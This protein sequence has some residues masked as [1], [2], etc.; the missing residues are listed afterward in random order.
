MHIPLQST[1]PVGRLPSE[2]RYP[3]WY[4]KTCMVWL[5]E[6]EKTVIICLAV[7]TEYR[8]VTDGQTDEQTSCHGSPH[9]AYVSRDKNDDMTL[10]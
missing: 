6:S 5:S 10:S 4:E 2:Y 1:T 8:R 7:S 3:V 9:Y